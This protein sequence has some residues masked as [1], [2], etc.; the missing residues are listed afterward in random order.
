MFPFTR[1][2]PPEARSVLP[3]FF[4]TLGQKPAGVCHDITHVTFFYARI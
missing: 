3:A 1:N 4:R 2:L